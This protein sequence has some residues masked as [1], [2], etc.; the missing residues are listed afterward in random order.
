MLTYTYGGIGG[1]GG[2][3]Q[4]IYAYICTVPGESEEICSLY[5]SG[6]GFS[7]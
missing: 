7:L 1:G 3:L 2:H 6:K 4:L 5:V